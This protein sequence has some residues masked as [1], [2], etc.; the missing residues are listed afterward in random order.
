MIPIRISFCILMTIS[1]LIFHG[2]GCTTVL[3]IISKRQISAWPKWKSQLCWVIIVVPHD[4][5]RRIR[6]LR[7]KSSEQDFVYLYCTISKILLCNP[8]TWNGIFK[9][10]W[11][12]RFTIKSRG[13]RVG[14][15]NVPMRDG[16]LTKDCSEK[17]SFGFQFR[18]GKHFSDERGLPFYYLKIGFLECLQ[19]YGEI[20]YLNGPIGYWKKLTIWKEACTVHEGAV[21]HDYQ[22]ERTSWSRKCLWWKDC[23]CDLT[24]LNTDDFNFCTRSRQYQH[25]ASR[26]SVPGRFFLHLFS[27]PPTPPNLFGFFHLILSK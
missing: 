2:T 11:V 9:I 20:R 12:G 26:Q 5:V 24:S 25:E 10:D 22:G 4:L 17:W 23:P 14:G 27:Q 21:I 19:I 1:S 6:F 18:L 13:S 8:F 7:I 3:Q 15:L 16:R